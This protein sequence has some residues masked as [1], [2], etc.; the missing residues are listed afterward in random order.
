VDSY[1]A[2]VDKQ[3]AILGFVSL[4]GMI[5]TE[6]RTSGSKATGPIPSSDLLRHFSCKFVAASQRKIVNLAVRLLAN[7]T[8]QTL[9]PIAN[10]R[11]AGCNKARLALKILS[12]RQWAFRTIRSSRR[13]SQ[14]ILNGAARAMGSAHCAVQ[15]RLDAQRTATQN[16]SL[17][18]VWILSAN[19]PKTNALSHRY[20]R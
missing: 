19:S 5:T 14:T 2:L 12:S 17:V 11:E 15:Q 16:D 3:N 8:R 13:Y 4:R 18:S 10:N 20:E 1:R 9:S 6:K 7:G